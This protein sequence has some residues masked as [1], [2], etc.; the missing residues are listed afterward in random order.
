MDGQDSERGESDRGTPVAGSPP[1]SG[2]PTQFTYGAYSYGA[3]SYGI[4]GGATSNGS[5]GNGAGGYGGQGTYQRPGYDDTDYVDA[6]YID[7]GDV[8]TG[9]VDALPGDTRSGDTGAAIPSPPVPY[10]YEGRHGRPATGAGESPREWTRRARVAVADRTDGPG[11]TA[12]PVPKRE[13]QHMPLWQELPL[14]LVVAFCLAV[15][16]RS[17]L[18][19]AF[20]IPSSSMEA[21]LLVGDRVLVNKV[22]YDLR[23]PERGEIVVFRGT[24]NWAPETYGEE[25]SGVL[26][27]IGRTF[28]D[29]VGVSQPGEKDFIKRVIGL[30]G[31]RIFCC[32]DGKVTVNG[33]PLEE[34]YINADSSLDVPISAHS[35]GSRRFD[36]V[37]VPQGYVF[38]MGDNRIV[39]QDSRCQ[40]PVPIANIIGRAFVIVWP[41]GRWD[42][43]PV[44]DTLTGV[45]SATA[46]GPMH[47]PAPPATGDAAITLPILATLVG[48]LWTGR[49]RR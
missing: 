39:S 49:R 3:S 5:G 48:S 31:D 38:V 16:I 45:P 27:R 14:L 36:E 28:G 34:P 12:T 35:C 9:D 15:L 22:I 11:D 41:S 24:D 23:D 40:G 18:M 13:R 42:N 10:D 21:T 47:V 1:P 2:Y 20:F 17:F 6:G 26:G 46:S 44:P 25:P 37:I 4:Y 7:A 29:L 8:D 33:V 19:Q 30:P 32:T 43:L